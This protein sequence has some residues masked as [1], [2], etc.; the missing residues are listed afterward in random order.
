MQRVTSQLQERL[1]M[2]QVVKAPEGNADSAV[3]IVAPQAAGED[4]ESTTIYVKN[5]A[6]A[7]TDA[8]LQ[9]GS[10]P[11]GSYIRYCSSWVLYQRLR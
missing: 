1:R 5:L 7:T 2:M 3:E 11:A 9:A 4:G 6:F 10:Y 8:G